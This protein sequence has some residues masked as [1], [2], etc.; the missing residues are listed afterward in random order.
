M[1][2]L[3]QLPQLSVWT[4]LSRQENANLFSFLTHSEVHFCV[5][6]FILYILLLKN[7]C[8]IVTI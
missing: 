6:I 1:E 3:N 8:Y 4:R 2:S 5:W 7:V